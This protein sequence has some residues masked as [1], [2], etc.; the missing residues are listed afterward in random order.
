MESLE[1]SLQA[2]PENP[3]DSAFYAAETLLPCMEKLRAQTDRLEV[4]VPKD[5]WPLPDYSEILLTN[6][7]Q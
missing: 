1:S 3:R 2:V 5:I 7:E 4:I 6:A